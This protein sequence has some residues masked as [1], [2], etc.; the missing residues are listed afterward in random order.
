M[1]SPSEYRLAKAAC[2]NGRLQ[3]AESKLDAIDDRST[4]RIMDRVTH[5]LAYNTVHCTR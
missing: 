4:E 5:A 3:L 1:L 2:L